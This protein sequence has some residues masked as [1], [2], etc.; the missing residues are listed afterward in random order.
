MGLF[1]CYNCD[2]PKGMPGKDFEAAKPQCPECGAT[3]N[4][5]DEVATIHFDPPSGM[6]NRG[7]ND[8]ACNPGLR[9]FGGNTNMQMTG[10]AACV[11]CRA[12]KATQ[13]WK[14]AAAA[15]GVPTLPEHLDVPVTLHPD[16]LM[17]TASSEPAE[18]VKQTGPCAGCP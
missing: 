18:G 12:C 16:K 11:T 9:I 10:L 14:D 17:V 8:A 4:L 6:R 3:G 2:G 13:L 1:R 15:Q 7:S 5:V